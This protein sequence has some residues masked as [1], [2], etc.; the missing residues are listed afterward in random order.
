MRVFKNGAPAG[1]AY[2]IDFREGDGIVVTIGDESAANG[3]TGVTIANGGSQTALS[4]A[5]SPAIKA[6]MHKLNAGVNPAVIAAVGDST[7]WNT[8]GWFDDL[9]RNK[10]GPAFPGYTVNLRAWSDTNQMYDLV[11]TTYQTGSGGR[12]KFVVSGAS[13]DKFFQV[14]DSA[15]TSPTGDIDVRVQCLIP[16]LTGQGYTLAGKY[17]TATNNRAWFVSVDTSGKLAFFWTTD[18]TAGTQVSK[19]STVVIPAGALNAV[20]WLRVTRSST[21][22]DV[23]FYYSTDNATWTQIGATVTSTAGAIFDAATATQFPS[24]GGSG[25]STI[26]AVEFYALQVF[27]TIAANTSPPVIDI[28]VALWNGFGSLGA[29]SA[30]FT[31]FVGNTVTANG[32][33]Q[34]GTMSGAP[35]LY[36]LNG[37]ASGQAIAYANDGTRQPKLTPVPSDLCFVVFGHNEVGTVAYRA[38]YKQLA[39]ALIAKWPDVGIVAVIENPRFSPAANITEHAIRNDAI[40]SLASSQ[41]QYTAID[42]YKLFELLSSPSSFVSADGIHPTAAGYTLIR[43]YVWSLMTPFVTNT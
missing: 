24:R 17:D 37:G 34:T 21:T 22:G 39:D 13:T 29:A 43:D 12:R 32:T 26:P 25:N 30:A 28:D 1:E 42:T 38:P 35:V 3:S 4:A 27:T 10:V 18:G 8:S 15:S 36:V 31:D 11:P 9:I 2:G 5:V 7:L 16:S 14:A 23:N 41:Q 6:F 20:V 33:G 19:L 40:A